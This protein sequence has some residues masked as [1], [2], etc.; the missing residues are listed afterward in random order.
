VTAD[1]TLAAGT[2]AMVIASSSTTTNSTSSNTTSTLSS[3][4]VAL[5]AD[6][7]AENHLTGD[8]DSKIASLDAAN[9][10]AFAP[11]VGMDHGNNDPNSG[12]SLGLFVHYMA[13]AF[14]SSSSGFSGTSM[15]DST[16]QGTA[17]TAPLV[18]AH[19]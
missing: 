12:A 13:S 15:L 3:Q 7:G 16:T 1:I 6:A 11:V 4:L 14:A 10:P 2:S 5:T 18:N 8:N 9:L 17:P 19:A